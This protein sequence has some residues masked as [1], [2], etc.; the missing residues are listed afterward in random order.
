[1]DKA[2]ALRK[3]HRSNSLARQKTSAPGFLQIVE[4]QK[5]MMDFFSDGRSYGMA[6]VLPQFLRKG[7]L[8]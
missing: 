6:P 5:E 4:G 8:S 2:Q 1:M 3:V 7:W